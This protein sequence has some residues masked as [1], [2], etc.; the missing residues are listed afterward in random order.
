[1]FQSNLNEFSDC[2]RKTVLLFFLSER[3]K[4]QN[5]TLFFLRIYSGS[6]TL[7]LSVYAGE[8]VIECFS[9]CGF[10]DAEFAVIYTGPN[11]EM[12]K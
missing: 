9:R 8:S 6:G 10:Y 4:I 7:T 2:F 5:L 12:N 3:Y 1:M 11:K